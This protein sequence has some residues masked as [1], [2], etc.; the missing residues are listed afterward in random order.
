MRRPA[1]E[2][3]DDFDEKD[4]VTIKSMLISMVRVCISLYLL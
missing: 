4:K 1:S 3:I 2:E